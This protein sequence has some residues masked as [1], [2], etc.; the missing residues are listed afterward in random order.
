MSMDHCGIVWEQR[1]RNV[2]VAPSSFELYL[3]NYSQ[4]CMVNYSQNRFIHW[5]YRFNYLD[6]EV[7]LKRKVMELNGVE[8]MSKW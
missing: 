5:D 7:K 3:E 2:N 8:Q 1:S 6:T 4:F